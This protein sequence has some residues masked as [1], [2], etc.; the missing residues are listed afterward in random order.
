VAAKGPV[1]LAKVKEAVQGG[2]HLNLEEGCKIEARVFGECFA[3]GETR[4]G[5]KAFLEKRN[6]EW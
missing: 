6:P 3:S 5:M 4:E 2:G 1:A